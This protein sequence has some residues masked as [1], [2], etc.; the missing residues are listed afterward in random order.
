MLTKPRTVCFCLPVASTIS[1]SVAP[2]AEFIMAMTSVFSFARS[3]AGLAAAFWPAWPSLRTSRPGRLLSSIWFS[4]AKPVADGL[5]FDQE[6]DC[7]S[8]TMERAPSRSPTRPAGP[9]VDIRQVCA[10]PVIF[11]WRSRSWE[12]F[13]TGA[14]GDEDGAGQLV[15][16]PLG[17]RACE[18]I[19]A[20]E[21]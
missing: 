8:L 14:P 18:P 17:V 20:C 19:Q 3:T 12:L 21:G 15:V 7:T 2:L 1:A 11:F 4:D 5:T 6:G 13:V 16:L 10:I 9:S